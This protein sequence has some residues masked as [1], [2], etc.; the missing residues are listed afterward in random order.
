MPPEAP[1]T[2]TFVAYMQSLASGSLCTVIKQADVWCS[3]DLTWLAVAEKVR[4]CIPPNIC[5]AKDIM[6]RGIEKAS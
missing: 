6:R 3:G 4:R 1:N 5:F 2:E